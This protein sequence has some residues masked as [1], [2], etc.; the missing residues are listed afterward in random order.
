MAHAQ[1]VRTINLS[2]KERVSVTHSMERENEVSLL[3]LI[4]IY[5]IFTIYDIYY[6]Y[7][8]VQREGEDF[9][10]NKLLN[11]AGRTVKCNQSKCT[12]V[13]CSLCLWVQR[14]G[15]DFNSNKLLNLAGL[16]VKYGLLNRPII[17]H[18]LTM[19]ERKTIN[20]G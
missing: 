8:W 18:V 19:T 12:L 17:A 14:E 9:N 15:E 7:L 11:I 16:R 13:R 2:G 10:S 5:Y 4:Y 20:H 6:L 1:S 3:Y